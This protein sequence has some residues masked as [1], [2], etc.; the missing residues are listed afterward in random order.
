MSNM[1]DCKTC[2]EC[3]YAIHSYQTLHI[4]IKIRFVTV[5]ILT[6]ERFTVYFSNIC[7]YVL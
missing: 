2:S 1:C 3:D 4:L 7:F 5:F 6:I